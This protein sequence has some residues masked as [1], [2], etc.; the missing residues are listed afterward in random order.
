[1]NP[2]YKLRIIFDSILKIRVRTKIIFMY[3]FINQM[4]HD[5][6]PVGKSPKF[7]LVFSSK[8]HT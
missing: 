3:A 8:G 1:M 2:I 4:K 5:D 7:C 6:F